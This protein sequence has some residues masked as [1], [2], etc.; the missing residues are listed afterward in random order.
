MQEIK[1]EAGNEQRFLDFINHISDKDKVALISHT[2]LDGLTSAKVVNEFFKTENLF[3]LNYSGFNLDFV[4]KLKQESFNK[5]VFTDFSITNFDLIKELE[6]FANI[7]IIDHHRFDKDL[8]SDKTVFVNTYDYCASYI[9]YVLFSKVVDLEKWDWLVACACLADWAFFNNQAWMK[10][11]YEKYE[12]EFVIEGKG[13]RNSGKIYEIETILVRAI[14]YFGKNLNKV[15]E[16]ISSDIEKILEL[17]KYS[18]EVQAEID[19]SIER[20]DKE[21]EIYGEIYFWE[22]NPKFGIKSI[23]CTLVSA[24]EYNKAFI[25]ISSSEKYYL[26]SARRQDK[27]QDMGKLLEELTEGFEDSSAGGHIPAAGSHFL[28]K[29]LAEFKKR[30]GEYN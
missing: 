12:D 14:I 7:L 11:V 9:C 18:G 16:M 3:F 23:V 27:K 28:K 17:K 24:R 10:K 5:I 21:K 22:F 2:D 13:I 25:F 20:F 4:K 1:F 15:Y 30:L 8:N 19:E 29:D 6:T 26:I